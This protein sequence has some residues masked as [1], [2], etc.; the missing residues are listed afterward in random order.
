MTC[1]HNSS[2][3]SNNCNECEQESYISKLENKNCLLRDRNKTIRKEL[4]TVREE[5]TRMKEENEMLLE[6]IK[7]LSDS[8]PEV[9]E[10]LHRATKKAKGE[11]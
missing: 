3:T 4:K 7:V 5:L 6:T 2:T 11:G 1:K 10:A 9:K 8:F